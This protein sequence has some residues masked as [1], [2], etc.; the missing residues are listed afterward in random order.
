MKKKYRLKGW[1]LWK[2]ATVRKADTNF[3][4]RQSDCYG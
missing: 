3:K 1:V 4:Y 2:K